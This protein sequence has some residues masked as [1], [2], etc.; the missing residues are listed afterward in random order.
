MMIRFALALSLLMATPVVAQT[1]PSAPTP[2]EGTVK[3]AL[4]TTAGRIVLALDKAHAPLTTANF[5]KYVGGG[6]Y[7]G[8]SIFS[9]GRPSERSS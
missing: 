4:D 9:P 3:V 1:T 8:L 7:D 5:L 2:A 6:R